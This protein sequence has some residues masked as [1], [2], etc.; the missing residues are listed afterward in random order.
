MFVGDEEKGWIR[1]NYPKFFPD[2]VFQGPF[3][4]CRKVFVGG[5]ETA[6]MTM[7]DKSDLFFHDYQFGPLFVQENYPTVTPRA[8]RYKG[9]FTLG[10]GECESEFFSLR[11]VY[12]R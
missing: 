2:R 8:A 11:F 12:T 6:R 9:L 1:I 7:N 4:V 5:E 10:E 3:D